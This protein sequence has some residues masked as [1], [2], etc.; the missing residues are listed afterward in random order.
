MST[1]INT[2]QISTNGRTNLSEKTSDKKTFKKSTFSKEETDA[3]LVA[4]TEW[5]ALQCANMIDSIA[6]MR[7]ESLRQKT[8]GKVPKE[9][10]FKLFSVKDRLAAYTEYMSKKDGSQYDWSD[11]R[12][13]SPY[14]TRSYNPG[15]LPFTSVRG[16]NK[17]GWSFETIVNRRFKQKKKVKDVNGKVT[18]VTT[19]SQNR[20]RDAGINPHMAQ[21]VKQLLNPAGI[22]V[23]DLS[24]PEKSSRVVYEVT[25]FPLEE[26]YID[27]HSHDTRST[28]RDVDYSL[29]SFPELDS[30]YQQYDSS[31]QQFDTTPPLDSSP[32]QFDTT[33]PQPDSPSKQ[34]WADVTKT[35]KKAPSDESTSE[36]DVA[37][38]S[39]VVRN[40]EEELNNTQPN[41]YD[42]IRMIDADI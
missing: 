41:E 25:A 34:S 36:S 39:N 16:E 11:G 13:D 3:S 2:T 32:Q 10:T 21:S 12:F 40:L 24:D 19:S 7:I 8:R 31:P 33:P 27:A 14:K 28:V 35:P 29:D 38:E 4:A 23:T 6:S 42:E 15:K 5:T 9:F 22:K 26:N 18:I 1:T 30:T 20:F 37:K 17:Q